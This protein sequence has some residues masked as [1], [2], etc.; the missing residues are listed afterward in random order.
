MADDAQHAARLRRVLTSTVWPM[1][2]RPSERSV[3]FWRLLVPLRERV[4]VTVRTAHALGS[5]SRLAPRRAALG[6]AVGGDRL[7]AVA[8]VGEAEHLGDGQ[9][10]QL[11]DLLGRAQALQAVHRRLD[12]VDRVLRADALGEHVVDA[13]ELEHGADAAAGDD[14]GTG[15]AG[16]R[17]TWPAP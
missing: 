7:D 6:L 16:R 8:L 12:E 2:R 14:A 17:K 3:A 11:G 4:W 5:T 15:A 13:A 9:A 10:A 1:R